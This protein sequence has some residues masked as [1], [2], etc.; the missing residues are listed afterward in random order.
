MG[1]AL[2]NLLYCAHLLACLWVLWELLHG[3]P[4]FWAC[5]SQVF[6]QRETLP[7]WSEA[8]DYAMAYGG[9]AQSID[10]SALWHGA[11]CLCYLIWGPTEWA[12]SG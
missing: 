12:C 3:G 11:S 5:I 6:P 8:T 10:I 4:H 7:S 9:G 2:L 1:F